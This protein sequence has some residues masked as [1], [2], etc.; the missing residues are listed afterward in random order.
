M[1]QLI[2][3]GTLYI[4]GIPAILL[5]LFLVLN[6]GKGDSN[7][8]GNNF[9]P[10]LK[11]LPEKYI[12]IVELNKNQDSTFFSSI[13]ENDFSRELVILKSSPTDADAIREF[14]LQ[15]FPLNNSGKKE[16]KPF[17]FKILKQATLYNYKGLWD[18]LL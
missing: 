16:K 12:D 7:E 8:L 18:S 14:L 1:S 2:T 3:K 10:Y 4:L 17:N 5:T 11:P 6:N 15:L 13:I 9:N